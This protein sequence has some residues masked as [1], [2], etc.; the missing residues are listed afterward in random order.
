MTILA[1]ILGI[2]VVIQPIYLLLAVKIGIKLADRPEEVAAEPILEDIFPKAQ[3]KER[4][5]TEEESRI[6]TV[7]ENFEN[8]VGDSTNQKEVI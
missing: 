1:I 8:Y 6:A 5:M 4:E 2:V 3:Q 7:W